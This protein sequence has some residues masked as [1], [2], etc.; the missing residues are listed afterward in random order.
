MHEIFTFRTT[1]AAAMEALGPNVGDSRGLS[2]VI[3]TVADDPLFERLRAIDRDW[4]R[5]GQAFLLGWDIH[6]SYSEEELSVA[7]YFQLTIIPTF[8][9]AG[10]ECGTEYIASGCEQCCYGR[11]QASSLR[12]DSKR[13]PSAKDLA[14][15]IAGEEWIIARRLSEL[16]TVEQ[17]TGVALP[18]V[19]QCG[20]PGQEIVGWNQL[21]IV[22]DGVDVGEQTQVGIS[23]FDADEGGEY[24]CPGHVIGLNVLSELFVARDQLR[25]RDFALTRQA[26]GVRRGLLVPRRQIL[27]SQRTRQLLIASKARG[28]RIEVAHLV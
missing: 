18:A 4:R 5:Q 27:I 11:R 19:E 9:P 17:L 2:R 22:G 15:T 7:E 1:E 14:Q 3:E 26:V 20:R 23:P 28:W 6:R 24:R 25:G 8:E 12:I 21:T 10:V 16:F 13:I